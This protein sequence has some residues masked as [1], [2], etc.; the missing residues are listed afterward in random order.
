MTLRSL[1][2][3]LPVLIATQ[4]ASAA[5]PDLARSQA[6]IECRIAWDGS[7]APLPE[8]AREKKPAALFV[9]YL[10][11]AGVTAYGLEPMLIYTTVAPNGE[12]HRNTG[13]QGKVADIAETIRVALGAG[14]LDVET[15]FESR[16][17]TNPR[18]VAGA[19]RQIWVVDE[20]DGLVSISCQ[21][22]R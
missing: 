4:P 12:R 6:F 16:I 20:G 3:A 1:I 22:A 21:D 14:P 2:L 7:A 13:V 18:A 9:H 11:P 19:P 8:V 15:K 5:E 10:P 17:V